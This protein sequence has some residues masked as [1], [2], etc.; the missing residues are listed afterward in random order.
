MKKALVLS[1]ILAG[2]MA[3][4]NLTAGTENQSH[5]IIDDEDADVSQAATNFDELN[6]RRHNKIRRA[7]SGFN[8]KIMNLLDE[9]GDMTEKSSPHG[10]SSFF[11]KKIKHLGNRIDDTEKATLHLAKKVRELM[12]RVD[13][14]EGDQDLTDTA[15]QDVEEAEK[16]GKETE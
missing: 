1:L 2:F 10:R 7:N 4:L 5:L 16:T 8:K 15:T 12:Q 3:A 6:T 13:K 14:L 11:K 9:D